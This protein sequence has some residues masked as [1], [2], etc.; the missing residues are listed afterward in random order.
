[1]GDK[2]VDQALA[3]LKHPGS[4]AAADNAAAAKPKPVSKPAAPVPAKPAAAAPTAPASNIAPQ[5]DAV[6]PPGK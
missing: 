3:E 2:P 1:N 4:V 5:T 6:T